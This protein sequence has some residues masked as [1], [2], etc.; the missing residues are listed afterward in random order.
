MRCKKA[1]C[2]SPEVRCPF[3]KSDPLGFGIWS[4]MVMVVGKTVCRPGRWTS[5]S[6]Y[7]LHFL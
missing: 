1:V 2:T 7:V 4:V 6:M 5:T 3:Q